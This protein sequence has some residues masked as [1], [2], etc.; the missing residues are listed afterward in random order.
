MVTFEDLYEAMLST[1]ENKRRSTDSVEFELHWESKLFKLLND[2]NDRNFKPTAYTFVTPPPQYR[3]IFACEF[4]MRVIHHYIDLRLRP[5]IE[6]E[7]TP[8]TYN[9]RVGYGPTEALNQVI[10]NIYEVSEGYTKDVYIIQWDIEGYFPN[11]VQDIVYSQLID[12]TKRR[13][14]GPDKE[15]LFYMIQVSIFSYPTHHCYRKSAPTAW[16]NVPDNKSLF[17]KPD[18]IGGAIGHLIWQNAM[19]YY[20]NDLDHWI[21]DDLKMKYVRFVDDSV[22]VVNNKEAALAFLMP[23][24][25]KRLAE[26]GCTLHRRKFYCQHYTKGVKFIGSY[27]KPGRLYLN[28]RVIYS[29]FHK[30]KQLNRCPRVSKI[31]TFLSLINSYTGFVKGRT[32][33]GVYRAMMKKI[34]RQWWK[35][36]HVVPER[37]CLNANDPYTHSNTLHRRYYLFIKKR[38]RKKYGTK[39]TN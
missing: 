25:R 26:K 29:S 36:V 37:Q 28:N 38:K 27:I 15:D 11:A 31:D 4:A 39:R 6:S 8:Y 35:Y 23:Q 16:N 7:L 22:I 1:R 3:E 10:E 18:G 33:Y 9:N 24:V 17:K 21:V 5:L 2:I 34:G 20:L 13:Y 19:N 12:I 30:I 14:E 32:E